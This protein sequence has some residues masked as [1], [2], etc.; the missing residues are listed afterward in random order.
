[1]PILAHISLIE[2][3]RSV[4]Q[5][6]EMTQVRQN[7]TEQAYRTLAPVFTCIVCRCVV[8]HDSE[9]V[10]DLPTHPLISDLI[11]SHSLPWYEALC[12][13]IETGRVWVR[14]WLGLVATSS[15]SCK[16]T[17]V[18]YIIGIWVWHNIYTR[19]S[20]HSRLSTSVTWP[21]SQHLFSWSLR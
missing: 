2:I 3:K 12:L 11:T 21:V 16:W 17:K 7:A 15:L 14:V 5:C 18:A 13:E 4:D 20:T 19:W 1:M 6:R 10:A 9:P 8:S